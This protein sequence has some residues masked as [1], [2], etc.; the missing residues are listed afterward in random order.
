MPFTP[1]PSLPNRFPARLAD[2]SHGELIGF[3]AALATQHTADADTLLAALR[4]TPEW[5]RNGVLVSTDLTPAL[6]GHLHASCADVKSVCTAW[7]TA[8]DDS[9]DGRAGIQMEGPSSLAVSLLELLSSH[10]PRFFVP[11]TE[12][13]ALLDV[14]GGRADIVNTTSVH[15]DAVWHVG[16]ANRDLYP[17][18]PIESHYPWFAAAEVGTDSD[19]T[20]RVFAVE[21]RT[22]DFDP[23]EAVLYVASYAYDGDLHLRPLCQR[24]KAGGI[25][26]NYHSFRSCLAVAPNDCVYVPYCAVDVVRGAGA[27]RHG[28]GIACFTQGTLAL[29]HDFH[30]EAAEFQYIT[31]ITVCGDALVVADRDAQCITMLAL[32]GKVLRKILGC[33]DSFLSPGIVCTVAGQLY[34]I[35]DDEGEIEAKSLRCVYALTIDGVLLQRFLLPSPPRALWPLNGK[36][37]VVYDEKGDLDALCANLLRV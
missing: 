21:N 33:A 3:A 29:V 26:Q 31:S 35:E 17:Y 19:G 27:V 18:M 20:R 14:R 8:W 34:M 11:L 23:S 12:T 25:F 2:L 6:L 22:S 30:A 9:N 15:D 10:S 36:L 13:R 16:F 32:D 28:D 1:A 37:V 7:R 24:F 5:V 4:P